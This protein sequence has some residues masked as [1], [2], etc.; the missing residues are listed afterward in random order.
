MHNITVDQIT[1]D[2]LV[3]FHSG[4]CYGLL[5]LGRILN[6]PFEITEICLFRINFRNV[7]GTVNFRDRNSIR[8][9][10]LLTLVITAGSS[11]YQ[12]GI[13]SQLITINFFE[14][15]VEFIICPEFF[16]CSSQACIPQQILFVQFRTIGGRE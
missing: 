9:I 2:I 14:F 15:K 7:V 10:D 6:Q 3:S 5:S 4:R 12:R 1:N 8:K 13:K 11:I 16:C